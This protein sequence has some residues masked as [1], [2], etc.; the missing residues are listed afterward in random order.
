MCRLLSPTSP[1]TRIKGIERHERVARKFV[2]ELLTSEPGQML[3]LTDAFSM[4]CVF[5][6]KSDAIPILIGQRSNPIRTLFRF[7]SDS[8]PGVIR[9]VFRHRRNG[10]RNGSE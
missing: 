3:L 1:H 6:R 7:N 10:V 9:T 2:A 8:V 5:R 4:F